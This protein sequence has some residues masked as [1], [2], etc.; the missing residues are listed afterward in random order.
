MRAEKP[1]AP[2]RAD[3]LRRVGILC[4][5]DELDLAGTKLVEFR[6]L[7]TRSLERIRQ[8]LD[9]EIAI[10]GQE[11]A[12]DGDRLGAGGG[13]ETAADAFDRVRELERI[14]RAGALL[15]QSGHERRDTRFRGRIGERAA[16]QHRA[17]GDERHFTTRHDDERDAVVE[18]DALVRGHLHVG[19]RLGEQVAADGRHD[20]RR[21]GEL[22][23]ELHDCAPS[24]NGSSTP[25]V[26]RRRS[27][28][29]F[30]TAC[31]SPRVTRSNAAG[32]S[33]SF[34]QSPWKTS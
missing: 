28:T 6:A 33:K 10:A 13:A 21:R 31:T 15:E 12:A 9:H 16:A 2:V 27:R 3:E 30:A 20:G 1:C 19:N 18:H 5:L 29:S 26:R 32:A 25:T 23:E 14:A 7:E 17:E 4:R 8:Q 34:C 24:S 11:L 22:H